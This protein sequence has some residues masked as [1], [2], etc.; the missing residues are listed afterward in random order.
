MWP[1]S[2]SY[3]DGVL[4]FELT[5]ADG[6]VLNAHSEQTAEGQVLRLRESLA[7]L[8]MTAARRRAFLPMVSIVLPLTGWCSLSERARS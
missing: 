7:G 5:L 2:Y 6:R 4:L 3:E 1:V 8:G